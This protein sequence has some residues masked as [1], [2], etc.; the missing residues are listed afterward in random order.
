MIGTVD[1]VFNWAQVGGLADDVWPGLLRDRDDRLFHF[2]LRHRALW[3][4]VFRPSPRQS[5]LMI[6]AG[7]VR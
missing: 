2:A 7:T 4:E 6:V 5:D 3:L 1:Y